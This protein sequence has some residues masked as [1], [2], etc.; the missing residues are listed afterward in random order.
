MGDQSA[1]NH[2]PERFRATLP[3]RHERGAVTDIELGALTDFLDISEA[4][5]LWGTTLSTSDERKQSV[6]KTKRRYSRLPSD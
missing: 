5:L 2:T 6:K 4:E 1:T 3:M